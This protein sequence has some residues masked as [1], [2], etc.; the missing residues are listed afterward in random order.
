MRH[1]NADH[2]STVVAPA[3][4]FAAML[5]TLPH[6]WAAPGDKVTHW[7][8]TECDAASRGATV[9]FYYTP[10]YDAPPGF[11]PSAAE[12]DG[13][14]GRL[15]FSIHKAWCALPDGRGVRAVFHNV[16]GAPDSRWAAVW[17]D[18]IRVADVDLSQQ[19]LESVRTDFASYRICHYDLPHGQDEGDLSRAAPGAV[20]IACTDGTAVA[21]RRDQAEFPHL[22]GEGVIDDTGSAVP[23]AL[24]PP[25]TTQ[26]QLV[27]GF[28][29]QRLP[30]R[31]Q[32]PRQC[33]DESTCTGKAYLVAGDLVRSAPACDGWSYVSFTGSSRTTSGWVASW[34]LARAE[35]DSVTA[36]ASRKRF[37][38]HLENERVA[39]ALDSQMCE[40]AVKGGVADAP[41][42]PLTP[43][44]INSEALLGIAGVGNEHVLDELVGG[45]VLIVATGTADIEN[46][47]HPLRF[48]IAQ[49]GE[50]G[51]WEV[52]YEWP[53]L[54]DEAGMPARGGALSA[55]LFRYAGDTG[56]V[57]IFRFG[58]ETY[59]ER[60]RSEPGAPT[61]HE[62]WRFTKNAVTRMCWIHEGPRSGTA[63]PPEEH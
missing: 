47:G 10:G 26:W 43:Y 32:H 59:L 14:G 57:R 23:C 41:V 28:A 53:I 2:R 15:N 16:P 37:R 55:R 52:D 6:A 44:L 46:N 29:G 63:A 24:D 45:D 58:N 38:A 50:G 62:V 31:P 21:G 49:A 48:G 35:P 22:A 60:R 33:T 4:L 9:T 17:I 19:T 7:I 42:N 12:R 13:Q 1:S 54:L 25:D 61:L 34:R 20:R 39:S 51:R 40:A 18:K 30:I 8:R 5:G 3:L 36:T 27:T 56:G 11:D